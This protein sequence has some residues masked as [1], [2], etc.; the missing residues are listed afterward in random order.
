MVILILVTY[1]CTLQLPFFFFSFVPF[2][3]YKCKAIIYSLS[4]NQS[5]CVM[6]QDQGRDVVAMDKSKYTEKYLHILQTEQF[7]K[8]IHDPTKSIKNEIQWE[9]RKFETRLIIH[10]YR[11]LFPT[12]SNPGRFYG[13]V[14]A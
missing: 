13:T 4:K 7:N 1:L 12:R 5:I 10:E 14:N 9:V 2:V 11:Q 6:K 3:P 8:L